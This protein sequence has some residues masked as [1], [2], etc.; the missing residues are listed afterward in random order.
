MIQIERSLFIE[1]LEGI[2][3]AVRN[4]PE[5]YVTRGIY[6]EDACIVVLSKHPEENVAKWLRHELL[7]LI[8]PEVNDG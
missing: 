5:D 3:T 8:V 2:L 6:F 1:L 7:K 4:T